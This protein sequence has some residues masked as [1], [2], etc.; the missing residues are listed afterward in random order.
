M[1]YSPPFWQAFQACL[2]L[3]LL[4]QMSTDQCCPNTD[5]TKIKVFA[6]TAVGKR[7]KQMW[8][9]SRCISG[10]EGDIAAYNTFRLLSAK[11]TTA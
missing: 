6:Q 3:W 5:N 9:E 11:Y 4:G 1:R 2:V 7:P 10:Q 8:E